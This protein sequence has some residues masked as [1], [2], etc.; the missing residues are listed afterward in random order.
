MKTLE[1]IKDEVAKEIHYDSWGDRLAANALGID[2]I[3]DDLINKVAI[4]YATESLKEAAK[5]V[6]LGYLSDIR[7]KDAIQPILSLVNELK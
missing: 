6:H 7:K 2:G 5:R 4:R 3:D 1:Q